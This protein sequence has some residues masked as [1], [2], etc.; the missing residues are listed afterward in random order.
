M[1]R[2]YLQLSCETDVSPRHPPQNLPPRE[3]APGGG[4]VSYTP[5]TEERMCELEDA[6]QWL[7]IRQVNF[8]GSRDS[9]HAPFSEIF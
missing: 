1:C 8:R 3:N 6:H 9:G 5:T 2:A 4:N 7:H